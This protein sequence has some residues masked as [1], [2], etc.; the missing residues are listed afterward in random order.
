[1]GYFDHAEGRLRTF[2]LPRFLPI[3]GYRT[4]GMATR[5][6]PCYPGGLREEVTYDATQRRR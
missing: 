2:G 4:P 1:M 3:A 5:K 6:R